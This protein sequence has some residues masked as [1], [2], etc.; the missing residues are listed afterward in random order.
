MEN[1]PPLGE[2][3]YTNSNFS[4]PF[5]NIKKIVFL[6]LGII[7][8]FFSFYVFAISAPSNFPVNSIFNIPEG[9]NLRNV[10]SNLKKMNIIRSRALFE[11]FVVLYGG[12]KH[13]I[14]ADYLFEEKISSIEVARRIAKGERHLAPV[15]IT[16][17]E[18]FST[19]DII[20][21][22]IKKLPYFKKEDFLSLAKDKE[23]YLFPDTYFFFTTALAQDVFKSL[24]N[25]FIKKVSVLNED[26]KKSGKTE[27]DIIKMASIIEKES[28]GD[29]DRE[30]ISGILWHRIAINMP[31]Q[32]D[33]APETY[34]NRGL[35]KNPIANPGL[36]AIKAAIYPKQSPYL[37][38]LH[39]K[40]GG[41]HY[42]KT[43][44]EHRA[45]ILKYL[46]N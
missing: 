22:A 21:S 13:I 25:N 4:K 30:V 38:Y 31:L 8:L 24:N 17:P 15:K 32:A 26:I 39:D 27:S 1:I 46:K 19:A 14:S 35:P 28:K 5:F 18:G 20:D 16:I 42:A 11:A 37:Y 9:A 44:A 12:D 6:F 36:D 43:F 3:I 33:A 45:N 29:I 10:S 41:I 34:T 23:G 7:I 40:E 2:H